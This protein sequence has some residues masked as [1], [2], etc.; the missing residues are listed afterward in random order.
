MFKS[1]ILPALLAFASLPLALTPADAA[2]VPDV[3]LR[4]P[5]AQPE[6]PSFGMRTYHD[7]YGERVVRVRPGGVAWR[8]GLEPSDTILRVNRFSL[9]RQGDWWDALALAMQRGGRVRLLVQ[10]HRTGHLVPRSFSF[11]VLIDPVGPISPRARITGYRPRFAPPVEPCD[12]DLRFEDRGYRGPAVP[13]DSGFDRGF[14]SR[15]DQRDERTH[16]PRAVDFVERHAPKSARVS[17][18]LGGIGRGLHGLLGR[19]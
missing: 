15:F 18:N 16:Q 10:D 11:P 7:G 4:P 14:E 5:L 3:R 17:I 9:R 2:P 19:P 8:M 1:A 13:V 6:L 12:D